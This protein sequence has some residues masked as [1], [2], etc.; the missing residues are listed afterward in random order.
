M[1]SKRQRTLYDKTRGPKSVEVA[2]LVNRAEE[3]VATVK[4]DYLPFIRSRLPVLRSLADAAAAEGAATSDR[5]AQLRVAAQDL[6][7][8]SATAGYDQ[9]SAVASSLE[10]LLA[11]SP[12]GDPRVV[13]V[14]RLHL[15]A[16]SRLVEDAAPE[17][18]SPIVQTLLS[19]LARASN[20]V[21]RG[22]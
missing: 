22:R 20:H 17:I 11:E 8:S 16:L 4:T 9:L 21:T 15:D 5:W 6:R 2:E 3:A 19:E 13:E 10:W 7:S 12:E 14:A 1:P 18:G